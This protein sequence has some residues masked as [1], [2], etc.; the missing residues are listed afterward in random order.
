MEG[1]SLLTRTRAV[2]GVTVLDLL[3]L[4]FDLGISIRELLYSDMIT[5]LDVQSL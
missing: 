5:L 3:H 2:S 1:L 4:G